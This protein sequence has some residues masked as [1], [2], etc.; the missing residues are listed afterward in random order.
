MARHRRVLMRGPDVISSTPRGLVKR[1]AEVT[2]G[3]NEGVNGDTGAGTGAARGA[4][5]GVRAMRGMAKVSEVPATKE[6]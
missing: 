6:G 2:R 5:G 3:A 1:E 4:G